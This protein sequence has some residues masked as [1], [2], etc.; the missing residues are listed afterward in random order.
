[1]IEWIQEHAWIM[2][3]I[4]I[5]PLIMFIGII[6]YI[7]ISFQNMKL[8]DWDWDEDEQEEFHE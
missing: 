2:L 3:W 5:T 7:L 1:M 8:N 6:H 4:L